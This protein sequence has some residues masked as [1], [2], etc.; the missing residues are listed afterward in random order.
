MDTG[1]Q[2]WR[3]HLRSHTWQPPTDVYET[4][5]EIIVRIE[6]AGMDE[7]DFEI[8]LNGRTLTIRGIRQDFA[9]K[10]AYHQMEI[11]YGEFFIEMEMPQPIIT[12]RVQAVYTN[13]FLHIDLPKALSRQI[14]IIDD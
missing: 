13:G 14:P 5:E 2:N 9:E 8:A 11:H 7:D 12:D 6:I 10:R 3:H 4:E 1:A